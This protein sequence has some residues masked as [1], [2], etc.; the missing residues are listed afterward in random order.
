MPKRDEDYM[1]NQRDTI[2]RAALEVLIEKGYYETTLRDIC[3]AA[4][5]SNG[6]LYSYF[7][8][9]ESVIVAACAID[10][11]ERLDQELPRTWENYVHMPSA[12]EMR[13]ESYMSRRLR[14]SL[15]FAAEITQMDKNPEGLSL[16]YQAHREITRRSL[17]RLKELGIISLPMGLEITTDLHVQLFFGVEYQL[18]SNREAEREPMLSAF[19]AGAALTAGLI[20]DDSSSRKK[21]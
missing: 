11:A 12:E 18:Q 16:L 4:E 3:R 19:L 5:V 7:S 14:L 10:H 2:A 20:E 9:R 17:L 15:Q 8:T 1:R 21:L 6:A 13:P